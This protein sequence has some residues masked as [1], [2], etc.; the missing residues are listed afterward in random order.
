MF[1]FR[2]HR[3]VIQKFSI[4]SGVNNRRLSLFAACHCR[5]CPRRLVRVDRYP[6][7][8]HPGATG[9]APL[10]FVDG[11]EPVPPGLLSSLMG[12][13]MDAGVDPVA[14]PHVHDINSQR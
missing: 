13:V 11:L 5:Q 3:Q 2:K 8:R 14:V 6:G 7:K 1:R 9:L 10:R 12:N 4:P